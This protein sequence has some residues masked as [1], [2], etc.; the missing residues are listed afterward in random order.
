MTEIN[1]SVRINGQDSSAMSEKGL[2]DR[3]LEIEFQK[4]PKAGHEVKSKGRNLM[5]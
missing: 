2:Y 3:I 1:S 4:N 5:A